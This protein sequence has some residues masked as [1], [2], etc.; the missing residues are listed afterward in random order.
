MKL[1]S[2]LKALAV[3]GILSVLSGCGDT[4]AIDW[5]SLG[6]V[7]ITQKGKNVTV[8]FVS[9]LYKT[10]TSASFDGSFDLSMI[11]TVLDAAVPKEHSSLMFKRECRDKLRSAYTSV[12]S[13]SDHY[14]RVIASC[15]V[16]GRH[17][18]VM[19]LLDHERYSEEMIG[20]ERCL[21]PECSSR[22]FSILTR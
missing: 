2:I 11:R 1:I 9:D 14:E 4:I 21:R 18:V 20:I 16:Y 10:Q 7:S 13:N 5:T 6:Q 8:S 3:V 12:I 15:D 22:F 19:A 17:S